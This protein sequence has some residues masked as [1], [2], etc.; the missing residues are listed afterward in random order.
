MKIKINQVNMNNILLVSKKILN[1]SEKVIIST[2]LWEELLKEN[3]ICWGQQI[4]MYLNAERFIP[5]KPL[6]MLI[7]KHKNCLNKI[8]EKY[9]FIDDLFVEESFQSLIGFEEACILI[10]NNNLGNGNKD[11]LKKKFNFDE[12]SDPF[13]FD[14]NSD[15]FDFDENS[16]PFDL[17][18]Y[19]PLPEFFPLYENTEWPNSTLYPRWVS[20]PTS[21]TTSPITWTECY[22][23]GTPTSPITFNAVKPLPSGMGM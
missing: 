22:S 3:L 4:D 18:E 11:G 16:D 1:I 19:K 20:L 17:K 10:K 12:N 2:D 14:E 5:N 9:I 21:G 15:P 23:S 8:L 6:L 7:S 13:N